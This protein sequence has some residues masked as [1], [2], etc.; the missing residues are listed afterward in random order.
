MNA[1]C[2]GQEIKDI[3]ISIQALDKTWKYTNNPA[4]KLIL[5]I[6]IMIFR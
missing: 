6:E 5:I 1:G 4:K 3:L 2:F